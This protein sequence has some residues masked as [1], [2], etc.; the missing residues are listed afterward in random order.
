MEQLPNQRKVISN[1]KKRQNLTGNDL[2]VGSVNKQEMSRLLSDT[3]E[4]VIYI[5]GFRDEVTNDLKITVYEFE[6]TGFM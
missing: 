5:Q 3:H 6:F 4:D 2:F 1:L